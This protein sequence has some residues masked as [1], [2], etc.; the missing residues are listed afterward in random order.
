MNKWDHKISNPLQ[1]GGI[2]TSVLDTGAA[3][4]VR[5]AWI[6][7]GSGLRYKVVLDRAMDIAEAFYNQYGL[8]WISRAGIRPPELAAM[9]GAGWL[10]NFGGGLMSTCGLSYM[11]SPESDEFGERGVHGRISNIP[12]EI[13]SIKQPDPQNGELEFSLTGIIQESCLF[14]PHLQ[15]ERTI[16]GTLGVSEIRVS[17]RVTNRGNETSPHMLLYHCNMG[18]PLID[19]GTK[20]NWKGKCKSRGAD[21]DNAIFNDD[22]NYRECTEPL[23]SHNGG[24]EAC[25]FIDAEPDAE[26]YCHCSVVNPALRIG[27]EIRFRKDQLPLL[28]NWQHWGKGEYVTALEPCT[29]PPNGQR[30]AREKGTLIFLE[31]GESREYELRFRIVTR[32]E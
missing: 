9:A 10:R 17:D 4:G 19:N 23:D 24:G 6:N 22:R 21:Q 28:T 18:W 30:E 25:G 2:E 31:P 11:G 3:R 15:L 29:N 14:G 7:T 1:I 32:Y 13:I 8:A 26:G 12:A 27:L 20:L 5:I 16:S